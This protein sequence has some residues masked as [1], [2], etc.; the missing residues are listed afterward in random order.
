MSSTTSVYRRQSMAQLYEKLRAQDDDDDMAWLAQFSPEDKH[1]EPYLP[2]APTPAALS[3]FSS[4]STSSSSP[5]T[6]CS[7]VDNHSDS[8]SSDD[9]LDSDSD[10]DADSES[11]SLDLHYS[12]F[13]PAVYP[14]L[15]FQ[16]H[17][18]PTVTETTDLPY[19]PPIQ[20]NLPPQLRSTPEPKKI[21]GHAVS[22]SSSLASQLPASPVVTAPSR[23]PSSA[24]RRTTRRTRIFLAKRDAPGSS[25]DSD[26][27]AHAESDGD[28]TEDEYMPSPTLS[29]GKRRRSSHSSAL[30]PSRGAPSRKHGF[31]NAAPPVKRPR[32]T[33]LSRNVQAGSGAA[34][35]STLKSNPWACPHCKWVQRNHRTPDL[36]RHIR[37]HTRLQRPAQWICCGVP[38]RDA[39]NYDLPEDAKPYIRDGVTMI[40]GCGKE[41][42][43]RDALKRHLDNE[44]LTCVGDFSAFANMCE[45]D[46]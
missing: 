14:S 42:S 38:L 44:H 30:T 2:A 17:D 1:D 9:G 40:G 31:E 46:D 35:A 43:R 6:Q 37:T 32:H 26:E 8:E 24:I 13:E 21:E 36:K 41:F 20:D 11:L 3:V 34:P 45:D 25:N 22:V 39:K 15:I 18:L 5:S 10:S 12:E 23:A 33:P 28:A 4:S 29:P 27:D 19:V 7:Q 16:S